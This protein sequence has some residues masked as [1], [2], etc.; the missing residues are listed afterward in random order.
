MKISGAKLTFLLCAV[1]FISSMAG[2]ISGARE[3]QP[4]VHR[5]E[6]DSQQEIM[7]SVSGKSA[8]FPLSAETDLNNKTEAF[9]VKEHK[10]NIALF[11]KYT[12]G[13]EELQQEYSVPVTL[14]PRSD[15]EELAAGIEFKSLSD[16]LQLIEDYSG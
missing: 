8:E 11:I 2:Y 3:Q 5:K 9:V 16:A 4:E 12:N 13:N 6:A 10:G 7:Q 15:R 1:T 14:L